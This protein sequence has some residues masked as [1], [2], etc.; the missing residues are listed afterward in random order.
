ML[1][2]TVILA[3]AIHLRLLATD[4][5]TLYIIQNVESALSLVL[6]CKYDATRFATVHGRLQQTYDDTWYAAPAAVDN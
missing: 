2:I 6:G 4:V 1:L 5:P 3:Y